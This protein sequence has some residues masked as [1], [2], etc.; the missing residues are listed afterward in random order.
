[1]TTPTPAPN[2][3]GTTVGALLDAALRLPLSHR[4]A[5]S[6]ALSASLTDDDIS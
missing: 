5:I 2:D 3:T 1:M 6:A 4:S